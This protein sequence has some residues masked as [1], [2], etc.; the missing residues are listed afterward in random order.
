MRT[1]T[2]WL[3]NVEEKTIWM[4]GFSDSWLDSV[5]QL[6]HPRDI[7]VDKVPDGGLIAAVLAAKLLAA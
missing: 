6:D 4:Q 1:A 5:M 3:L 7:Y 2:V